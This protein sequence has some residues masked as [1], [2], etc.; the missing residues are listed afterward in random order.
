MDNHIIVHFKKGGFMP[1]FY[2]QFLIIFM[3]V[4]CATG[5][6]NSSNNSDCIYDAEDSLNDCLIELERKYNCIIGSDDYSSCRR[7]YNREKGY[8]YKKH[9]NSLRRCG[10]KPSIGDIINETW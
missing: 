7:K 5:N 1:Y 4:G 2:I 8:C 9:N 6:T 10:V 3:V